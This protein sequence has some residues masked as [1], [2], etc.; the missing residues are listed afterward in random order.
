M[1]RPGDRPR[2]YRGIPQGPDPEGPEQRAEE[3][4]RKSQIERGLAQERTRQAELAERR[5]RGGRLSPEEESLDEG[6]EVRDMRLKTV[7]K[8]LGLLAVAVAVLIGGVTLFESGIIG[9]IGPLRPIID[10][11]P[12]VT[13]PPAPRLETT[14]GETL[15]VLHARENEILNNYTWIDQAG[16]KVSLPIDRAIEL[17]AQRGLPVRSQG[18][19]E[20]E[21]GTTILQGS[22]SGRT[23]ET[24]P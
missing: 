8:W 3:S 18:S 10:E 11:A 5:R 17:T 7:V 2:F 22:S 20:G 16:G 19:G 21:T 13:P 12:R 14:N 23:L 9:H 6:Y 1:S 15:N 24:L 4:L